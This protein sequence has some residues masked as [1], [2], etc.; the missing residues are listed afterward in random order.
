MSGKLD[1]CS[2]PEFVSTDWR[3]TEGGREIYIIF[4]SLNK[5][6]AYLQSSAVF[7]LT[8]PCFAVPLQIPSVQ[9]CSGA[10]LTHVSTLGFHL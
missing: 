8:C 9:E 5:F 4:F 1:P 10:P 6:S 3:E 2:A 7:K